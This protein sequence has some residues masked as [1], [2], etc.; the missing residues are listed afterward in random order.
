MMFESV[1]ALITNN[2]IF[3]S[4][5]SSKL[6][7]VTSRYLGDCLLDQQKAAHI[8]MNLSKVFDILILPNI[9]I[10]QDDQEEYEESPDA[11][12]KNDL[13]E[14]ENETRRKYC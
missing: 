4:R 5:S 11:Y 6:V 8:K 9:A 12:I 10:T 14:S 3:A 13:E 2:K 1:W 7:K